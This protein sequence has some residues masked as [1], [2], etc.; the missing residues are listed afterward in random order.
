MNPAVE[1]AIQDITDGNLRINPDRLLACYKELKAER[2]QLRTALEELR[3][4]AMVTAQAYGP[5]RS[6][7][8]AVQECAE[9]ALGTGGKR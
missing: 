8:I 6:F 5:S 9:R 1:K 4:R 2:D 3:T 7:A